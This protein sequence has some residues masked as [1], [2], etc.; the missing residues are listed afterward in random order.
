[1]PV[2]RRISPQWRSSHLDEEIS[3]KQQGYVDEL[4]GAN[5]AGTGT[6]E[7]VVT[8]L[9]KAQGDLFPERMLKASD[10]PGMA[11]G[12]AGAAGCGGRGE[13]AGLVAEATIVGR[14][15]ENRVIPEQQAQIG[16]VS[17]FTGA[18]GRENTETGALCSWIPKV[19]CRKSRN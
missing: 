18:A 1:M 11:S 12:M 9:Q 19:E 2:L 7:I 15:S 16:K 17:R 3:F 10:D 14:G 13:L 5:D 8:E 4:L 6:I